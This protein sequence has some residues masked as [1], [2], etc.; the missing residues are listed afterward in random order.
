MKLNEECQLIEMERAPTMSPAVL[1]QYIVNNY[2]CKLCTRLAYSLK[3]LLILE[4]TRVSHSS[5]RNDLKLIFLE[6]RLVDFFNKFF[7]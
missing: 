1:E 5:T 2:R 7:I 6:R 4:A 3:S